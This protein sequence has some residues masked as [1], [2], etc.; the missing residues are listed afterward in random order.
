MCAPEKQYCCFEEYFVFMRKINQFFFTCTQHCLSERPAKASIEPSYARSVLAY[1]YCTPPY[2]RLFLA[3]GYCTLK[4]HMLLLHVVLYARR[5][6]QA[7]SSSHTA[8]DNCMPL[9][10]T[11]VPASQAERGLPRGILRESP[12]LAC[13]QALLLCQPAKQYRNQ[14]LHLRWRGQ[15]ATIAH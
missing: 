10:L 13:G 14:Q 9:A 15:Q 6:C 2:A 1:R 5:G 3:Y 8:S 11:I 12:Q 4:M 7:R